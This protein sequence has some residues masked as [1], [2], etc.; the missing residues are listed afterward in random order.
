MVSKAGTGWL[1]IF[2]NKILPRLPMPLQGAFQDMIVNEGWSEQEIGAAI[3]FVI[4]N[5][6][7]IQVKNE[8]L[9]DAFTKVQKS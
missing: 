1:A 2:M 9:M 4:S 7:D 6:L 3:L 8:A 5:A